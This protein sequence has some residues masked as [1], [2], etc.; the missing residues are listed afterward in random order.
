M[1]S[2]LIKIDDE[3]RHWIQDISKRYR[4]S[5][6]RAA[7]KVNDEMLRFYWSMGKDI[8]YMNRDA[9]YGSGFYK[10]ISAD[11]QELFP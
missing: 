3:Y 1:S 11:L 2:K 8:S 9:K 7:F 10:S 5:Q 6:I 4:Q